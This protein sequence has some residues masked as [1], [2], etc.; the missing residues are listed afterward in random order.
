MVAI[1]GFRKF[2]LLYIHDLS[3]PKSVIHPSSK[4]ALLVLSVR[5]V[6]VVLLVSVVRNLWGPE[7]S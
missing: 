7:A 5:M 1:C 2:F 6:R 4:E 3:V